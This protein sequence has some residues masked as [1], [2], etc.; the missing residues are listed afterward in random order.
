[1]TYANK[2]KDPRWQK[3]RLQILERD[4]WSCVICGDKESTLH[5]HHLFYT[6]NKEPWDID[7]RSLVTLCDECHQREHDEWP[8]ALRSFEVAFKS[9]GFF[10]SELWALSLALAENRFTKIHIPDVVMMAMCEAIQ[11]GQ[12]L[13][14]KIDEYFKRLSETRESDNAPTKNDR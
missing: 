9:C 5:V 10:S 14:G 7:D 3:K 4:E 13:Q 11:D 1:M 2:L 8:Q 12:I 6:R